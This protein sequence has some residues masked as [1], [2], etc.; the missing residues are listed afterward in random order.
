MKICLLRYKQIK[1][2][3]M[4]TFLFGICSCILLSGV[5]PVLGKAPSNNCEMAV[6]EHHGPKHNK[7][8]KKVPPP[9]ARHIKCKPSHFQPFYYKNI[10]YFYA[11]GRFYREHE[12]LGYEVMKPIVGMVIPFMPAQKMRKVRIKNRVL[13]LYNGVLYRKML[14]PRGVLFEVWGFL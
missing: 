12:R 11:N 4:R 13:F 10:P 5:N 8:K 9:P 1:V 2:K 3:N 14:T 6:T 7:H